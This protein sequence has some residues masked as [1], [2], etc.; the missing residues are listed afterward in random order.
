VGRKNLLSALLEDE[1]TAVNSETN[2]NMVNGEGSP[3]RS[4]ARGGAVGAMSRSLHQISIER[5][6]LE[7]RIAAGQNVIDLDPTL[8]D[9]SFIPDRMEAPDDGHS[10]LLESIREYGQQVPILVRPHPNSRGRYQIAYGHRRVRVMLDLKRPV[11]A[12]IRAMNDDELVV[13]QGQENNARKDLSFIER[14]TFAFRL[15]ERG[16]GRET[17]MAALAVDKTELSRLISVS[18]TISPLVVSAIGPAPAAG[19]R[20]WMELAE[21]IKGRGADQVLSQ[22]LRDPTFLGDRSD[23]RFRRLFAALAPLNTKQVTPDHWIN[24]QGKKVARIE[25]SEGRFLL[26][27]D[28]RLAPSF[29]D[30]IVNRLPELYRAFR[31]INHAD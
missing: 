25:R 12:V 13:A 16:F 10:A 30:F 8:I 27:L 21:R 9:G 1:L 31:E 15:E 18:R 5:E 3:H 7:A 4:T 28:E 14:A 6:E 23:E 2:G 24:E 22:L 17:I 11:R 20:R 26:S 19:R 29:G